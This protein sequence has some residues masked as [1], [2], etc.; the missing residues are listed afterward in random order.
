LAQPAE[1]SGRR[2]SYRFETPIISRLARFLISIPAQHP[3]L[4]VK[5][6]YM[7]TMNA[8]LAVALG[9]TPVN[10]S[11]APQTIRVDE[12][13]AAKQVGHYV[14][15]VDSK[16]R[17]RLSGFDRRSGSPYEVTVDQR[18]N[19]QGTVGPWYVTFKVEPAS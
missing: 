6:E 16:G 12:A 3:P 17:T 9:L 11:D 10:Y 4:L 1:L 18:G 14:Q 15:S 2:L 19:V 13:Q 7:M 8:I 5:R